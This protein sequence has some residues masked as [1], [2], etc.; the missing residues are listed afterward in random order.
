MLCENRHYAIIYNHHQGETGG[1]K[2]IVIVD[3]KGGKSGGGGFRIKCNLLTPQHLW[4][5]RLK[6]SLALLCALL[7][8]L[9]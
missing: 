3:A 5:S 9:L 2:F 6:F 4:H 8:P 7:S 1:T